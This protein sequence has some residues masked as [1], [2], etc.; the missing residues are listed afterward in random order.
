ML[1]SFSSDYSMVAESPGIDVKFTCSEVKASVHG[2]SN[3]LGEW[4]SNSV[5]DWAIEYA[6]FL[7]GLAQQW[8]PRQKQNL[9]QR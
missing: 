7:H 8:R 9:A 4:V 6:I 3:K 1:D 5:S 2:V